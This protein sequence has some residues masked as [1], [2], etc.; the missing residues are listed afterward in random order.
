MANVSRP[1][2][3]GGQILGVVMFAALAVGG[4]VLGYFLITSRAGS[5]PGG[6]A[7]L[8]GSAIVVAFLFQVISG[9]NKMAANFDKVVR[10]HN[11]DYAFGPHGM[12]AAFDS[13]AGLFFVIDPSGVQEFSLRDVNDTE[14]HWV[15]NSVGGRDKCCLHVS[16]N[17]VENPLLKLPFRDS[18][19]MD[20]W[21][22]R[23]QAIKSVAAAE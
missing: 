6:I 1:H 14:F 10:L 22:A 21:K 12:M 4:A 7:F 15:S 19:E 20:E 13:N 16:I 23:L 3:S 5:V 9:M 18:N 2:L 11:L 8:V 17:S